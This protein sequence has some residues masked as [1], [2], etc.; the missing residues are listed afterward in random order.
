MIDL[1]FQV[2]TQVFF[3]QMKSHLTYLEEQYKFIGYKVLQ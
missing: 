3:S 1:P 2:I